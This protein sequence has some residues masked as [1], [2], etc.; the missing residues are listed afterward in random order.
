MAQRVIDSCDFYGDSVGMRQEGW[1]ISVV[2]EADITAGVGYGRFPGHGGIA[3][4]DAGLSRWASRN[5]QTSGSVAHISYSEKIATFGDNT[6]NFFEF[7]N[8]STDLVLRIKCGTD[9]ALYVYNSAG[10]LVHTTSADT[11]KI[12]QWQHIKLSVR[13]HAS[14]G[15]AD[16]IIDN[17]TIFNLTGLDTSVSSIDITKFR[18]Y[19]FEGYSACQLGNWFDDFLVCDDAGSAPFNAQLATDFVIDT[20]LPTSDITEDFTSVGATSGYECLDDPL[21][22]NDDANTTYVHS[23]TPADISLHGFENLTVTPATIYGV[24]MATV[25]QLVGAG[26][27][28]AAHIWKPAGTTYTDTAVTPLTSYSTQYDLRPLNPEDGAAWEKADVDALTAGITVVA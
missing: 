28:T 13:S 25:W 7:Y 26:A 16:L 21:A 23:Q 17:V 14:A 9:G 24:A 3:L 19:G 18:I 5:F 27:R 2:Q 15:T 12:E 8:N 1:S 6:Q 22:A 20:L 10:A 4:G 11:I